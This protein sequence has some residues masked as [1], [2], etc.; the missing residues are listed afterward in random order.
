MSFRHVYVFFY[1]ISE[2]MSDNNNTS[3]TGQSRK[4]RTNLEKRD[5]EILCGYVWKVIKEGVGTKQEML[6]AWEKVTKLFKETTGKDL[7][8]CID[9]SH[10]YLNTFIISVHLINVTFS[11]KSDI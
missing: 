10:S 8:R 1:Y 4:T 9:K 11:D 7:T 2:K 5:A 3:G 6:L